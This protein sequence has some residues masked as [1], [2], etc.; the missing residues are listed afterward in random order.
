L[1]LTWLSL[2]AAAPAAAE[3]VL[4]ARINADIQSSEP[5]MRRDENTDAVLLHVGEGLVASREDG[6]VGPMLAAGWTVSPDG[7]S[8]RF[9]LRRDVRFH[10]GEPLTARAVVWSLRRYF[11]PDSHWRCRAEFGPRG[12]ARVTS[13]DAPDSYT[14]VVDLDRPAPLFLSELTRAD[15]GGTAILSP[16]SVGKDGTWQRPVGTGPFM[17]AEWR[18]NQYVDL[19]RYP[20]Y[21]SQLGKPDGNGGGKKALVDRVRFSV[22]PDDSAASAALLRGSL[23][24][25]DGLASNQ[26]GY[27]RGA[28]GVRFSTSP[29]MDMFILMLQTADP[30]LRD[31]RLRRAIAL[32][33]DVGALTRVA[34]HGMALAD[35]S[36]VARVSPFSGSAQR[37]LVQR[38]LTE[39]R[40][41]VKASGYRGQPLDLVV[42]HAP[43]E[44]FDAA[45]IIQAQAREAGIVINIVS[46]D[47]ASHFARY[48]SGNYQATVYAFS[49]RLDPSFMFDVLIG[50]KTTEPRKIWDSATARALLNASRQTGDRGARQAAFDALDLQFRRDTPGVVLFNT[51]RVTALR[52]TVHGY[53]SWPAQLQ[54]L[55]NV[56]VG[57]R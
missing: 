54:R 6:S 10:N 43:P 57:D 33:I 51:R 4:H 18:R 17:W 46:L 53:R 5:G 3:T 32:S 49:P 22:I 23:D 42:S 21:R 48:S 24:V 20:G 38:N 19:V 34:A 13:I 11:A 7:R 25:L 16:A 9:A 14:V 27:I 56:S 40:A 47:W 8:Y 15:C 45:I 30:V 29:S 2:S 39:A 50:D 37:A 36:V 1:G 31:P 35:S 41:L 26:L 28:A 55:W 44:M 52:S 12:I